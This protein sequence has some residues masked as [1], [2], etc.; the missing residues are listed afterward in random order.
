VNILWYLVQEAA[1]GQSS[2]S[3]LKTIYILTE[4]FR[5]VD[6]A[7][8]FPDAEILAV[9]LAEIPRSVLEYLTSLWLV[10]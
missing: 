1:H 8:T 9:D 4:T 2:G 10:H 3:I 5:V 7:T 6:A